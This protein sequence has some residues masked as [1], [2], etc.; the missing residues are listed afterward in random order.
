MNT[1]WLIAAGLI[2]I[3]AAA[4]V[5]VLLPWLRRTQKEALATPKGMMAMLTGSRMPV[6]VIGVAI[7]MFAAALYLAW[8]KPVITA[9]TPSQIAQNGPMAPEHIEMIKALQARLEQNPNDG[10][11][12]VMLA[13]SYAVLG[14]YNESAAAYDKAANLIQN[15][16][17]LLVDYADVLAMANGKNLQGKPLELIQSALKIDPNNAKGLLLAGKA[18]YQAGDFN[19]AIVYWEKLLQ[20]LPPDSPLAKQIRDNIAQT[21]A[22]ET[23]KRPQALPDRGETQP[24]SGSAQIAGV[25]RLSPALAKE[26]KPA[27]TVFVF[28][29]AVSG[30]PM[31]VAVIRTQVKDL[32]RQFILNDSLAMMP[33]MKLSNFQEVAVSARV[34][35]SGNATPQSGD[36]TGEVTLVKV[37]TTNVQLLIDKIVP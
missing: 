34:S 13:R 30:P 23:G 10:K 3:I 14:R 15:N 21:R 28:A 33:T 26:A 11:G 16:A 17:A 1:F 18:A 12:W 29:K 9:P 22:Q 27:D 7:A 25:V 31:P 24:A 32:P 36:L 19:Q 6:I 5:F 20:S 35:K 4:L 8:S 37:G 2:V